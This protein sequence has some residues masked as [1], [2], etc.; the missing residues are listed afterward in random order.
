MICSKSTTIAIILLSMP[1]LIGLTIS[2]LL[3]LDQAGLLRM[4]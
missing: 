2:V 1:L 3:G 4:R